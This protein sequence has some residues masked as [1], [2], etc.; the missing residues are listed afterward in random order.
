MPLNSDINQDDAIDIDESG[1]DEVEV[2]GKLDQHN[3]MLG[4]VA[5][6]G[7]VVAA[8]ADDPEDPADIPRVL[9]QIGGKSTGSYIRNWLPW[10]AARAGY[11]GEW[12]QPDLDEQVLVL[13]PSGNVAQGIIIG[14]LYRGSLTFDSEAGGVTARDPIPGAVEGA[15]ETDK[16]IHRRVYQDGTSITYDR[17]IHNLAV[18]LKSAPDATASLRFSAVMEPDGASAGTGTATLQ[19]GDKS[20][21]DLDMKV[22]TSSGEGGELQLVSTLKTR[23]IAGTVEDPQVTILADAEAEGLVL[24]VGDATTNAT[25]AKDGTITLSAGATKITMNPDGAVAIDAG[26]NDITIAGNVKVTGTLDVS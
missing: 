24:S 16:Y 9:V 26:S 12:W 3:T 21:P 17:S 13:A 4:G 18:A 1:I 20:A 23:L 25:I 19:I 7:R 14:S 2:R 5:R 6:I 10:T 15:A 22:D 11:D 8:A